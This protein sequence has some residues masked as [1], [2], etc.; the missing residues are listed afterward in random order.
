M[1]SPNQGGEQQQPLMRIDYSRNIRHRRGVVLSPQTE[2][3]Y[4]IRNEVH[5]LGEESPWQGASHLQIFGR[6]LWKRTETSSSGAQQNKDRW[7]KIS[8]EAIVPSEGGRGR[9][10]MGLSP[11]ELNRRRLREQPLLGRE[12]EVQNSPR[13]DCR[14]PCTR[15][16]VDS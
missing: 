9:Y 5:C 11:G 12:K 14:G 1:Y 15:W 8:G 10:G 16:V 7:A 3:T 2:V 13:W 6:H 4:R